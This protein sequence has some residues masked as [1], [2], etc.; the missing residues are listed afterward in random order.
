MLLRTLRAVEEFKIFLRG[1]CD[2]RRQHPVNDDGE[3]L[4]KL[5]AAEDE[6]VGAVERRRVDELAELAIGHRRAV[7]PEAVDRDGVA[8]RL[9][10]IMPVRAHAEGAAGHAPVGMDRFRPNLV[11]DGT[12]AHDEDQ[13][14]H[15]LIEAEG[16]AVRLQAVKPCTRCPIPNIDPAT[17][18][19]DPAVGDTLQAYRSLPSMGGGVCFG[20]NLIVRAGAG[21]RK[22]VV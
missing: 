8:R 19:S 12:E 15:L 4:S 1:L 16:P 10:G 13:L 14:G 21:D 5:I 20:M 6:Q 18:L 17:A 22:S 11:L 2:D 3:V 7:D 9:V